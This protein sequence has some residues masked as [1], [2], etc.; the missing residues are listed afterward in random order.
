MSNQKIDWHDLPSYGY[1]AC[2][3]CGK[4]ANCRKVRRTMYCEECYGR[5]RKT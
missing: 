4:M 3:K 5:K 1:R 2:G